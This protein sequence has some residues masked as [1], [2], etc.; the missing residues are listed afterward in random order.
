MKNINDDLISLQ[1]NKLAN[2]AKFLN[3]LRFTKDYVD[4]LNRILS[5]S[6]C[7]EQFLA[8][9]DHDHNLVIQWVNDKGNPSFELTDDGVTNFLNKYKAFFSKRQTFLGDLASRLQSLP[10]LVEIIENTSSIDQVKLLG[11]PDVDLPD[12]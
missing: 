12:L 1:Y 3:K 4:H 6:D 5:A 10:M 11:V 2:E 8:G 7:S 9:Y